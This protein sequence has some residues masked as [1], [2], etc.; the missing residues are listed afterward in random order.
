[1]RKN[2]FKYL[3]AAFLILP[4]MMIFI[5][6]GELKSIE[7]KTFIYSKVEVT[8]SLSKEEYEKSYQNIS[9]SFEESTVNYYDGVEEDSYEY[10]FEN[11]KIYFKDENGE[12]SSTHD[13]EI[14]GDYMVVTETEDEGTVKIYFKM[15]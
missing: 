8:G 14:S 6:C 13:A 10:K 12:F 4:C 2:I 1:M 9:F 3:L 7:G 15:K 11:N 5:A